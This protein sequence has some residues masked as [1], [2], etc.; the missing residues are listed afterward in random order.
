MMSLKKEKYVFEKLLYYNTETYKGGAFE[1][2]LLRTL[3]CHF[4]KTSMATSSMEI[5]LVKHSMYI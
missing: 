5:V 3:V 1:L 2:I 4:R